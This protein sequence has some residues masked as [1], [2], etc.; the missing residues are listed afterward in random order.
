MTGEILILKD[1]EVFE[2]VIGALFTVIFAY[3]FK[4]YRGYQG[5]NAVMAA[6]ISVWFVRKITLNV[7]E[8]A[9]EKYKVSDNHIYF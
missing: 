5:Y 3:Y 1:T 4:E 8:Y 2:G 7:F 6:W 9:K